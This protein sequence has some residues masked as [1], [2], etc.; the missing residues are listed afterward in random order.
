M[1][2]QA[3][4]EKTKALAPRPLLLE[5]LGYIDRSGGLQAKRAIDLGCGAGQDT[6]EL[7]KQGWSVTA[8]DNSSEGLEILKNGLGPT[9]TQCTFIENS[10]EK[11]QSLPS[12]TLV[13]ASLSLPFC[14]K[15]E[16]PKFWQKVKSAVERGGW[17]AADFFGPEDDWVKTG[18]VTGHSEA[19]IR[20]MLSDFN[21]EKCNE[22]K[23]FGKTRLGDDKHWHIISVIGRRRESD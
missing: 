3:Y 10:F 18:G 13:Y 21:I 12:A 6:L 19:E 15:A 7:L 17:F 11:I 1:S 16:F 2:W 14:S 22:T 8:V 4:Y 20:K 23:K 9:Q 5:V